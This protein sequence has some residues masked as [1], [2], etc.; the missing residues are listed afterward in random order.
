MTQGAGVP[1]QQSNAYYI[2]ILVLTVFSLLIMV[3]MLL[4][5]SEATIQLLSYYDSLI[6]FIFLIDFFLTL[7]QTPKKADYFFAR[8]GWL[9]LLGSIPPLGITPYGSLFRLARISR[10]IRITRL[11]RGEYKKSLIKD[12][13]ENRNQYASF[14]TLLLAV[15]VLTAASFLV[16]QFESKSLDAN[17]RT[18]VD[19]LWY[20]IVTI[21][22]VGYGDRFPVTIG[23]RITG[24]FIMFT[25]VGIIGALASI[26]A[27]FLVGTPAPSANKEESAQMV[28]SSVEQELQSIKKELA[29][30]RRL[31]EKN[32]EQS[33]IK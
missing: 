33:G 29:E 6:C 30:V 19:A 31:L 7:R 8:G 5:L 23:G 20:S 27:S 21:T 13:L 25:G 10:L 32:S 18:G 12:V 28:T 17:I 22:T 15:I 1:R 9:D 11:L 14:I 24:I 4:P 2:F 3:L 16:L 26:L